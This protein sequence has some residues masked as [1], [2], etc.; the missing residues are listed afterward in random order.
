MSIKKKSGLMFISKELAYLYYKT[1]RK[2]KDSSDTVSEEKGFTLI[3]LYKN[4]GAEEQTD[5]N[6]FRWL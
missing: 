5:D 3:G 4:T 2:R 6:L 1:D